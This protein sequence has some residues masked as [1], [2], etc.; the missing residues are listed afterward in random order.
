VL[1]Y[2]PKNAKA[3][4][5]KG[6]AYKKMGEFERALTAFESSDVYG[7]DNKIKMQIEEM[8]KA[9]ASQKKAASKGSQE[10][11]ELFKRMLSQKVPESPSKENMGKVGT[12]EVS[13][14]SSMRK[15][16]TLAL[17]PFG[18]LVSPL[19]MKYGVR[20]NP[21][22]GTGVLSGL[23]FYLSTLAEKKWVKGLLIALPVILTLGTL[24]LKNKLKF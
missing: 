20:K 17:I 7:A 15:Y 18:L 19:L 4:F 22:I 2:D 13:K 16:G 12:I 5:R 6:S 11:R 3:Y 24:K 21:S 10:E 1:Y 8:K 9:L 23:S 14:V